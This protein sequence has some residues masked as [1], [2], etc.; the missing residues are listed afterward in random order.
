MVMQS[1]TRWVFPMPRTKEVL[2]NCIPDVHMAAQAEARRRDQS[3]SAFVNMLI[4]R[5]LGMPAPAKDP[6]RRAYRYSEAGVS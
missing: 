1:K 5:E 2:I 4:R 6:Q 3:F